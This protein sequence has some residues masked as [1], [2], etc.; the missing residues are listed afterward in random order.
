MPMTSP[1]KMFLFLFSKY[2]FTSNLGLF[3]QVK[4]KFG[5]KPEIKS[6]IISKVE[7]GPPVVFLSCF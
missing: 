2:N 5:I 1:P 6:K 7:S 4:V 3:H